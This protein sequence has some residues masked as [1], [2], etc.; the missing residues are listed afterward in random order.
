MFASWPEGT[1]RPGLDVPTAVDIYAAL[2]N[3]DVFAT[4]RVERSWSPD[5]IE[6]WWAEAL[7]RE[8]LS[9]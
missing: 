4:L 9:S 1:L 8:L 2:C 7:P 3:V 6:Q 5:R